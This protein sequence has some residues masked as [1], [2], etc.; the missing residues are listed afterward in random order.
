VHYAGIEGKPKF[1]EDGKF[2]YF[3]KE[4]LPYFIDRNSWGVDLDSLST[5]PTVYFALFVPAQDQ[6]PMKVLLSD[7]KISKTNGFLV[8]QWGGVVV[9][10]ILPSK[11]RVLLRFGLLTSLESTDLCVGIF[12]R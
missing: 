4:R 6:T 8:P 5:L 7:G 3:E 11:V 2:Y 10:K 12:Q 1:K 9:N